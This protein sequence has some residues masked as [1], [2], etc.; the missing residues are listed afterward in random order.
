MYKENEHLTLPER[1]KKIWRYMD[2]TKFIDLLES[3]NIFLTRSDKFNDKFEGTYPSSNKNLRNEVYQKMDN[4]DLFMKA[5]KGAA[6][7]TEWSRAYTFINC[8]H[9]N[10]HESAG[11]WNLYL[12]SNE[13]IAIQSTIG[14]LVDSLKNTPEDIRIGSVK[15]IDY[16]KDWMPEDNVFYP[17]FHKRKSFEHEKE[18]RLMYINWPT[19]DSGHFDFQSTPQYNFGKSVK[20][21]VNTLIEKIYISPEAPLWFG[22]LTRKLVKKYNLNKDVVQS[23]L[24][25]VP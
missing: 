22:D 17:F 9:L 6:I 12:K 24:S 21:D 11:M 1:N 20:I 16:K 8:W 2:F 23:E 7:L 18:V 19:D 13:G 25:E 15:Y 4:R 10:E 5:S 3:E 14:S